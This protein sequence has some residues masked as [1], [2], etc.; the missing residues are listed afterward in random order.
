[1]NNLSSLSEGIYFLH[2]SFLE[3]CSIG[4]VRQGV[5]NELQ[6]MMNLF[7]NRNG[8]IKMISCDRALENISKK[9]T[10]FAPGLL[11]VINEKSYFDGELDDDEYSLKIAS[12]EKI[13]FLPTFFI[14]SKEKKKILSDKARELGYKINVLSIEDFE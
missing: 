8:S 3:E 9:S 5:T 11:S 1:M 12:R 14:V 4:I 7:F 10:N 2:L 6:L 13:A